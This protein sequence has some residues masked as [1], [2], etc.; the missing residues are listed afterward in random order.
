MYDIVVIGSDIS[1]LVAAALA[2]DR[3]ASTLMVGEDS[4]PA[5]FSLP[6]GYT[7]DPCPLPWTG[8]DDRGISIGILGAMGMDFHPPCPEESL[9]QVV[10]PNRTVD[11]SSGV[12]RRS[13]ETAR[14]LLIDHGTI[15]KHY[16]TIR[17]DADYVRGCIAG[18]LA[19]D[20]GLRTHLRRE[21]QERLGRLLRRKE[22]LFRNLRKDM[23]PWALGAFEAEYAF[24]SPYRR[25]DIFSEL[26]SYCIDSS[27]RGSYYISTGLKGSIVDF[28]QSKILR[29]K[30]SIMICDKI[31]RVKPEAGIVVETIAGGVR[32]R[33]RGRRLF[34]STKWRG[35]PLLIRQ[36]ER[37]S[38]WM[39]VHFESRRFISFPFTIHLGVEESSLP[40]KMGEHLLIYCGKSLGSLY[41][42]FL[43]LHASPRG[44]SD[45]APAGHRALELTALL[46]H[47]P[48]CLREEVLLFIASFMLHRLYYYF[49]FLREGTKNLDVEASIKESRAASHLTGHGYAA[50][51]RSWDTLP[52]L[53]SSSPIRG[54]SFT[55]GELMPLLGFD[56]DIISA[57]NSVRKTFGEDA[58]V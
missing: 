19:E 47:S 42:P 17:K 11:F 23:P 8:F 53:E 50:R 37:L 2:V 12:E 9:L 57:V 3:G 20:S 49:P 48:A 38:K 1:A 52:L 26:S 55:G 24:F 34:V 31:D 35:F 7:F 58:Y 27:L 51:C 13:R 6:G 32:D 43:Y 36:E 14:D 10:L 22:R 4:L 28:L 40:E 30:G 29:G 15:R 45:A 21:S 56:G 46:G 54:L 33:H 44:S 18:I 41:G 25:Y 16:E 5:P 39:S